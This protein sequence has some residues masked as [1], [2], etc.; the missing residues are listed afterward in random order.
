MPDE[1]ATKKDLA[2][3][4]RRLQ[5]M[6]PEWAKELANEIMQHF[7]F[8]AENLT[9]D[10]RGALNDKVSQHE[11]RLLIIEETVGLKA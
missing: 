11:D 10:F 2:D 5:T 7:N 3:L 9:H 1:T 6:R 4:E 8:V